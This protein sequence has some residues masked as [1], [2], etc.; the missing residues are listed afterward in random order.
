LLL[1][2]GVEP[3]FVLAS[4]ANVG[5]DVGFDD[6]EALG[7]LEQRLKPGLVQVGE[8]AAVAFAGEG[9]VFGREIQIALG[10]EGGVQ[11]V[12]DGR[13]LL[14]GDVEQGGAGPNAV[15]AVHV[16]DVLEKLAFYRL[17]DLRCGY[18]TQ[19]LGAIDGADLIALGKEIQ[20]VPAGAAAQVQDGGAGLDVF[21]EEGIEAGNIGAQGAFHKGFG[22]VVVVPEGF[23]H[24]M[25]LGIFLKCG[26]A[27]LGRFPA[28]DQEIDGYSVNVF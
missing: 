6:M 3:F 8:V 18:F 17:T 15:E 9:T 5:G 1:Q 25:L 21:L 10:L 24:M 26:G 2:D 4:G 16:I 20:A 27:G 28:V 19:C 7:F 13:Q 14:V 12:Q 11:F 23:I 22:V